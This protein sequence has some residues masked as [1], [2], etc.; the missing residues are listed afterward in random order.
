MPLHPLPSAHHVLGASP[1]LAIGVGAALLLA[2]RKLFWFFVA[3]VGFVAAME[4]ATRYFGESNHDAILIGSLVAGVIG[5]VL[6]IFLQKL[7]VGL[8]GAATGAYLLD[9]YFRTLPDYPDLGWIF[10]IAAAVAGALL[11][12]VVFRWAL[13]LLTSLAGAHLIGQWLPL[14]RGWRA[15]AYAALVVIGVA[16]QSRRARPAAE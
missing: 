1:G 2:G 4:L 11:M 8:A 12:A 9:Q 10:L 15:A 13:I 16:V 5:A 6:A 14:P 3:A 7:A